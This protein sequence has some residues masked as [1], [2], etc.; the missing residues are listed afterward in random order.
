MHQIIAA[1]VA[2]HQTYHKRLPF[3]VPT[4]RMMGNTQVRSSAVNLWSSEVI[5][6]HCPVV[7]S[8]STL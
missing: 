6:Q 3:G 4:Q 5:L 8:Y 1:A 7:N 2:T